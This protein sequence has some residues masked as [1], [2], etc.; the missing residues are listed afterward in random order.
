MAKKLATVARQK[1]T[2]L[3]FILGAGS[4]FNGP[5]HHLFVEDIAKLEGSE[6]WINTPKQQKR[7]LDYLNQVNDVDWL[8]ISPSATFETGKASAS[9]RIG[10][11]DLLYNDQQQSLTTSGTMARLIVAEIEQPKHHRRI[12]VVNQSN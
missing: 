2:K 12:T 8:G 4:L 3:I 1:Q 10:K 9:Y 7:E 5:D 6:R 11:D